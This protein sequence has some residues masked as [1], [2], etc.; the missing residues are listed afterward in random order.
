MPFKFP[1]KVDVQLTPST[2]PTYIV[3][4]LGSEVHVHSPVCSPTLLLLFM[5]SRLLEQ[6][7]LGVF[8]E[9]ALTCGC[10]A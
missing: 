6:W 2:A 8:L 7:F 1:C 4:E 10:L 5:T 9:V 3:L